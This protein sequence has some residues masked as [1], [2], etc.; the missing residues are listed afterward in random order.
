MALIGDLK[1]FFGE[2][3]RLLRQIAQSTC[4]LAAE[5][6][7]GGT[8]V[9]VTNPITNPVN[10]TIVAANPPVTQITSAGTTSPI[11]AGFKSVSLVKTSSNADSV[12]ITLSDASTYVMTEQGEVFTDGATDGALLPAYTIS[13][14][15]TY[16]WHGIK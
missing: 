6:S 14:T 7:G 10:V 13:G 9:V 2:F 15:G 4:K 3:G 16:K 1:P 12:T 11:P 5:S 8:N